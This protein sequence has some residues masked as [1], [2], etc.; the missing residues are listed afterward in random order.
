ME[1]AVTAEELPLVMPK[2]FLLGICFRFEA[3]NRR[4]EAQG[5]W[6]FLHRSDLIAFISRRNW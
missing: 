6:H 5:R 4:D 2:Q 3:F 1:R